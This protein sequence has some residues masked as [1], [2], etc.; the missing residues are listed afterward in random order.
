MVAVGRPV[1]VVAAD[2][3]VSAVA[4]DEMMFVT[5]AA[6]EMVFV[7]SAADARTMNSRGTVVASIVDTPS[8]Q[9]SNRPSNPPSC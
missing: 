3:V 9:S 5:G 4:A 2:R 1:S 7:P 8:L 6:D